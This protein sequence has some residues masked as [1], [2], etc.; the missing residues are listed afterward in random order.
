MADADMITAVST[1]PLDGVRALEMEGL[2]ICE[3]RLLGKVTLRGNV[4]D[5][6]FTEAAASV[7]GAA[8]PIEPMTSVDSGSYRIFWKAFDEWLIW[9]PEGAQTELIQ[10]LKSAMD[11]CS[12]AVVDVSDYYHV[13]RVDGS[14]SRELLSKGCLV[15]L[16][17]HIFAEGQATGTGFHLATIFIT[18]VSKDGFDVMIRWSFADYLWRYFLDGAREWGA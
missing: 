15:D 1:S 3:L 7:L 8:L 13:I 4:Q 12:K 9:T 16:D 6:A 17:P 5:K 18:R 10:N 2:S 14:L 11:H